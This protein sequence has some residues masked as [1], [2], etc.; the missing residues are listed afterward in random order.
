[1]GNATNIK[2]QLLTSP[3]YALY[4]TILYSSLSVPKPMRAL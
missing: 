4:T 3:S 2:R 1:M